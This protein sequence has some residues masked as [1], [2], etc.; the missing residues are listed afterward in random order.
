MGVHTSEYERDTELG[1]HNPNI[2][3]TLKEIGM[4]PGSVRDWEFVFQ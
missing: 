3:I 4:L 2:L 1:L